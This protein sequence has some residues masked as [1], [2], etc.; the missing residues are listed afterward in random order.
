MN[1]SA[2]PPTTAAASVSCAQQK[3]QS[4]STTESSG[5]LARLDPKEI[6]AIKTDLA[7][8]RAAIDMV[9]AQYEERMAGIRQAH[10]SILDELGSEGQHEEEALVLSGEVKLMEVKM[11]FLEHQAGG[12][13][14]ALDRYTQRFMEEVKGENEGGPAEERAQ[15]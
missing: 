10:Q 6:E 14:T 1:M 11:E 2:A 12:L 7:A 8:L 15:D 5:P 13:E 9:R 4:M 3:K